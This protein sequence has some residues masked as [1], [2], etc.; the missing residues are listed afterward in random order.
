MTLPS[1][2]HTRRWLL[3]LVLTLVLVP[4]AQAVEQ[5][6]ADAHAFLSILMTEEWQPAFTSWLQA[7]GLTAQD[8]QAADKLAA[9]VQALRTRFGAPVGFELAREQNLSDSL[10]R[11]IYVLRFRDRPVQWEL[12]YYRAEADWKLLKL[13]TQVG[14]ELL[15]S[16]E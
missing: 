6:K 13:N 4:A 16:K 10:L 5:P 2:C 8:P 14:F 11:L 7:S 15:L 9:Q 3:V 12:V 1:R